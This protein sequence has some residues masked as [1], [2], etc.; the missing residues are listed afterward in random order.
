MLLGREKVMFRWERVKGSEVT[1]ERRMREVLCLV[2][3][4]S[5]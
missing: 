4:K 5:R 1:E 2:R 3:R